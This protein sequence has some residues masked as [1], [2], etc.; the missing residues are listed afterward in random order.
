MSADLTFLLPEGV[1][2][3]RACAVIVHEGKL[4]AM[5][6]ERSPYYYL[7]GGR[8][9]LH[10]TA[11]Q[12]ALREV[13][14]ELGIEARISRPL[15]LCQNFFTEDVSHEKYHELC[16]YFLMDISQTDL[17]SRGESFSGAERHHRQRFCWLPFESLA[18]AYLYPL[19]IKERIFELPQQLELLTERK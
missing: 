5:R 7:P 13:R 11:E 17:L 9:H 4:L 6:D 8:L 12:A 10:E 1:F 18:D 2:S 14:E 3:V 15:W 19:F 16:F